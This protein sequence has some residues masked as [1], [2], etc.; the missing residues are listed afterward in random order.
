MTTSMHP[1]ANPRCQIYGEATSVRCINTGTHWVSWGKFILHKT[2]SSTV[3]ESDFYSWEC[4]GP[5]IYGE[6]NAAYIPTQREA[7]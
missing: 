3:D 4:D 2:A 7:A 1:P 6:G 5:H